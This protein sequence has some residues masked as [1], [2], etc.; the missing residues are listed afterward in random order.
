M[1]NEF[2]VI[3]YR[4]LRTFNNRLPNDSIWDFT[5]IE[6]STNE[7]LYDRRMLIDIL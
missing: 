1:Y 5:G 3:T 4:I 2:E 7:N 6:E